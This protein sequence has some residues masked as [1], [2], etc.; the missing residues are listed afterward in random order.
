M[1][2][3]YTQLM[4][5][6]SDPE[7]FRWIPGY[8]GKYMI[9]NYGRVKSFARKP[10][11]HILAAKVTKT[12]YWFIHLA[13]GGKP[14]KC[15]LKTV[16]I[17]R[18][19]ATMFVD[20]PHDFPEVDHIDNDKANNHWSNL[21]WVNHD[22]NVKKDQAYTYK[23]WNI[24][25]PDEIIWLESKRQVEER[26]GKSYGWLAYRLGLPDVPSRD[27]WI[28]QVRRLKGSEKRRW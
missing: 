22:Y 19:V 14:S 18:L 13:T 21:Q 20:N 5:K 4:E 24:H 26:L 7:I 3:D 16:G 8:E 15:R 10:N 11:G 6:Y 28:C 12:G 27:G 2:A 1:L 23:V 17:A 9:S 25:N